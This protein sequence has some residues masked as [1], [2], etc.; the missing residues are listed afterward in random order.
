MALPSKVDDARGG[1]TAPPA[2][3]D[4]AALK[5]TAP[6]EEGTPNYRGSLMFGVGVVLAF[7]GVFGVWAAVAPLDSAS[8]APGQLIVSGNRKEVAHLEGGIVRKIYVR[9]GA[10]VQAGDPIIELDPTQADASL[11]LLESRLAFAVARESRLKAERAGRRVIDFPEWLVRERSDPEIAEILRAEELALKGAIDVLKDQT[12]IWQY[13]A[14]QLEEENAGL[15]DEIRSNNDQL[16]IIQEEI[17]DQK[18]LVDRGLGIRRVLLGLER[19]ATEI[20]GRRARAQAGIAR[21]RQAI[22]ESRLRIAEL[23]K[24]RQS[25]ID[26]ELGQ[27]SSEIAGLRER[28]AAARDVQQRTIVRAPVEGKVVNLQAHT[29]GGI[30]RA[31]DMLMELVPVDDSLIVLARVTPADI[32][33]V[34]PGLP[35]QV[36]LSAF[37]G[38]SAPVL[39][40]VLDTV[41]ADLLVDERTGQSYY[42]ARVVLPAN[43]PQL[44]DVTL[45]PG[46]PAE[47][48]IVTGEQ[49]FLTSLIRPLTDTVRRG[50][51]QN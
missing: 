3:M 33:I 14:R 4:D 28:I 5:P 34:R 2:P 32:D 50:A 9:E 40:A 16:S 7:F 25:E 41:S 37:P 18:F 26:N 31:G 46:M 39:D 20:R 38:R 15:R 48:S 17:Q 44:V 36:R 13:R 51:T 22:G 8:L 1:P 21:N 6:P 45:Y 49:T 29:V 12:G 19:Q 47:V 30:V 27:L 24:A 23:Q 10:L 42:E 43:D 35:A 11:G